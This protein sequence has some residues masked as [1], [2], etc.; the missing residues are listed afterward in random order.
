MADLSSSQFLWESLL[1][2]MAEFDGQ[3]VGIESLL[4]LS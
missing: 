1:D 2:A 4:K 3:A